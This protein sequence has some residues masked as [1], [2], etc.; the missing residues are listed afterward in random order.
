MSPHSKPGTGYMRAAGVLF[1]LGAAGVGAYFVQMGDASAGKSANAATHSA[2]VADGEESEVPKGTGGAIQVAA[3]AYLDA[4]L[5]LKFDG[6]SASLTRSELGAA[7]D[8]VALKEEMSR[9][10]DKA[11]ESYVG[12]SHVP[13]K[14][15]RKSVEKALLGLKQRLDRGPVNAH[16]DLEARKVHDEA[17]G[18]GI[19]VFGSISAIEV[20][21]RSGAEE[22]ELEGV[23]IPAAM[24]VEQLG[25]RDVSTV[26][27]TFKTKFSVS[28]K[29]RNDNLKL[30]ASKIDGLVLQPGSPS[31]LTKPLAC[32]LWTMVSRWP[33]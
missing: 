12:N 20:A 16:F 29:T 4:P 23:E 27:G 8:A 31:P 21:L 26:I 25:I 6:A 3:Q 18:F 10:G 30:L 7:L 17:A 1:V 24:T 13:V 32:A 5:T 28:E 33:T 15:K 14:V 11:P 9:L 2:K 19:D 22:V